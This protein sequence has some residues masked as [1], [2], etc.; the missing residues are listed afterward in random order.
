[1]KRLPNYSLLWVS[2][3]IFLCTGCNPALQLSVSSPDGNL[4][5]HVETENGKLYYELSRNGKPILDK[6]R[7]GFILKEDT[8]ADHLEIT[9]AL[10]SA[11]H[12]NKS[13][14]KTGLWKTTIMR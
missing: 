10:H 5:L 9:E 11:G 14:E 8:L 6:S 4:C 2:F 12:G 13:G 3:I 7:L 1:M